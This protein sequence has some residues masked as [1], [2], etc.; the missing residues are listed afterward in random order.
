MTISSRAV[1]YAVAGEKIVGTLYVPDTRS[2][3]RLPCVVL[4][5][6]WGM[7]AGGDLEDY[8]KA[9]VQRGIA[10]LTFDY[11][12]LGKSEGEPRQHLDP[13]KQIEDFRAGISFVRS[14]PEID[15]ERIGVWGSSYGGGHV[16]T[17]AATD[18][19]VRC[20]V[21]QVPTISSWRAARKRMSA[22]TWTAQWASFIK[23]REA[24]FAGAERGTIQTVSDNSNDKVAY[25]G[26]DSFDYMS[27]EGAR[28]QTW[29][30]YT[31]IASLELARAYEPGS[32]LYRITETPLLMIVAD[33]DMTTPTDL[34]IQA[35]ESLATEKK[36]LTVPG[37]HYSV[38]QKH[39]TV[40]SAAAADWF[41]YHL[42]K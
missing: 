36:L 4:G 12:N 32:Y 40:T 15:P 39:F 2:S 16:L 41:E 7:V 23:D 18:P 37:G 27:S 30:N 22:E 6:G 3:T 9:I 38:Y 42:V 25:V 11:R 19:R 29:R 26:L 5:H 1:S 10:A 13:W 34:Q 21:S 33:Q 31:T 20:V 24:V 17:V 14:Q 35:F 8:A 28:C